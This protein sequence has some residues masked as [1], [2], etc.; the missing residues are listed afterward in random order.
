[1]LG[2]ALF[3][4][5][6][7]GLL[8]ATL[9]P[10]GSELAFVAFLQSFPES[11]FS[12]WV[13]VSVGNSIGGVITMVMGRG[14]AHWRKAQ[15]SISDKWLKRLERYGTPMLLLSWAPV[16]GDGLCLAAGWLRLP[17]AAAVTMICLG[18]AAR[19]ALLWWL[20]SQV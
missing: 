3:G 12:A 16:I 15:P 7:G 10:G 18:K 9:L 8:S 4:L 2:T 11:A 14:V 1:M 20:L 19:Y 17:W 13:L 6:W 5:F